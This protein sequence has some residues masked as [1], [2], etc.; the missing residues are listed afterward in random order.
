MP[1]KEKAKVD[2]AKLI[3][4]TSNMLFTLGAVLLVPGILAI[5]IFPTFHITTSWILFTI[6][7]ITA[8]AIMNTGNRI[9]NN[10][11]PTKRQKNR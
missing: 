5:F 6:G 2:E 3:R 9:K 11:I 1:E 7:I 4:H 8:V 10:L